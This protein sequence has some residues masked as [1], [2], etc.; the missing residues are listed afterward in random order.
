MEVEVR[1]EETVTERTSSLAESAQAKVVLTELG[2]PDVP[3]RL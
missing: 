1:M 2:R 3:S